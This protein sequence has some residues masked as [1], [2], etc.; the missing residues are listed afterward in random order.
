VLAATNILEWVMGKLPVVIFLLIFIGQ[1]VRGFLRSRRD[2]PQP[3]AKPDELEE[4]R[5][6]T[7]IQEQIRRRIAERRGPAPT[8][9]EPPPIETHEPASQPASRR[10]ETTQMP[11]PIGGPLRRVFEEIQ[12]EMQ[13]QPAPP[14][15]LPIPVAVE[16]RNAE[17]ERQEQLTEKM[18]VLE[19]SRMLV[20]RR[21][22]QVAAASYAHAQS[23]S[24]L[25]SVARGKLLDDLRDA[26]SLRRAFVLREVLGPPV[27]LR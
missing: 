13:P 16:R 23:E 20:E 15:P 24:S 27:G 14:P 9:G 12:R 5:R 18:R 2:A 17:L 1:I 19:E 21:A 7:E 6:V 3:Q 11:E 25:R 4:H 8:M 10:I 22:T 26:E